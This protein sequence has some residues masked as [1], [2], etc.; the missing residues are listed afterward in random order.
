MFPVV[1]QV[2]DVLY[3]VKSPCYHLYYY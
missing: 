3:P 2:V 1:T